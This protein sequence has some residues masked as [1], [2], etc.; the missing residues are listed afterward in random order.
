[1]AAA[2]REVCAWRGGARAPASSIAAAARRM[3]FLGIGRLLDSAGVRDSCP[4]V[5]DLSVAAPGDQTHFC[6]DMFHPASRSGRRIRVNRAALPAVAVVE[7]AASSAETVDDR[8]AEE[9]ELVIGDDGEACL[10]QR[11]AVAHVHVEIL[12]ARQ[13]ARTEQ[14]E[15]G[16]GRLNAAA[17]R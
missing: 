10:G 2:P 4:F 11:V 8:T 1:M 16:E 9:M 12:A 15:K 6:G 17:H 14:A 13:P 7:A 3:N 5:S